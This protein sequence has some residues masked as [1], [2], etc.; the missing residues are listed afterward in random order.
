[1]RTAP[2]GLGEKPLTA[3][4]AEGARRA[5]REARGILPSHFP[6]WGKQKQNRIELI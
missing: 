3:E 4:A 5:Q 1:M 2:S 6:A